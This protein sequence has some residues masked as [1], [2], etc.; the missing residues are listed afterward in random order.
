PA[1]GDHVAGDGEEPAA[2]GRARASLVAV[3]ALD[4]ADENLRRE[5]V[6]DIGVADLAEAKAVDRHSVAIV[7]RG[8]GAGIVP[9]GRDPRQL[10]VA[11][12][13]GIPVGAGAGCGKWQ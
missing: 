6:G 5:V 8:E 12:L 7:E 1:I 9:R 11:G 4:R 13:A 3:D 10:D 2:E